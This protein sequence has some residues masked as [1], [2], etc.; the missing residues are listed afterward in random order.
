MTKTILNKRALH[1]LEEGAL[2]VSLSFVSNL[3]DRLHLSWHPDDIQ[4]V[5]LDIE[6][7]S[8]DQL[9]VTSTC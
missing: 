1:E 9:Y 8:S 2:Y 6:Q 5:H 3:L 4:A 7:E